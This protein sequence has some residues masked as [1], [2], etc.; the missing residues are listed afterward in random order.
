MIEKS[1]AFHIANNDAVIDA[2]I[3]ANI[4]SI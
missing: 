4:K 3:D 1:N 2:D